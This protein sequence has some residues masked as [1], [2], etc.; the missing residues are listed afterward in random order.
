MECIHSGGFMER[1]VNLMTVLAP[2][3]NSCHESSRFCNLAMNNKRIY[4]HK[5]I[6]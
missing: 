6:M 5:M 3:I 2:Y 4:Y 1:M